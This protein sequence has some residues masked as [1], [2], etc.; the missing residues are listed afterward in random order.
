MYG[1][2]VRAMVAVFVCV[3][4]YVRVRIVTHACTHAF[5]VQR[6][7]PHVSG[8]LNP[9]SGTPFSVH[10]E[11]KLFFINC[12]PAAMNLLAILFD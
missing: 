6:W 5:A 3:N 10:L 11:W 4:A 12:C 9:D 1:A 8:P 2:V 7:R